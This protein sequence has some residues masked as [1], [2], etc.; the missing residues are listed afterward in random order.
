MVG[1]DGR[2]AGWGGRRCRRLR[3]RRRRV[4]RRER[5]QI[6]QWHVWRSRRWRERRCGRRLSGHERREQR[7]KRQGRWRRGWDTWRWKRGWCNRRCVRG[8]RRQRRAWRRERRQIGWRY[9]RR[10]RRWRARRCGRR[11]SGHERREQRWK[12]RL[13]WSWRYAR[14]RHQRH[15]RK[16][17]GRGHRRC[18][19]ECLVA[20][21]VALSI[22]VARLDEYGH[23]PTTAAGWISG[24]RL[25]ADCERSGV[26][27]VGSHHNLAG[28]NS[29]AALLLTAQAHVERDAVCQPRVHKHAGL[30]RA[31]HE[32]AR[33]R[34]A[35]LIRVHRDV[36]A[37]RVH[38]SQARY[39]RR[40][41]LG[42][43]LLKD[44]PLLG[45]HLS[46]VLG[47]PDPDLRVGRLRVWI[48]RDAVAP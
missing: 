47:I 34:A 10:S 28:R 44:A 39:A 30:I 11:L 29:G 38:V 45:R 17:A 7:W 9:E 24:I 8:G 40:H 18:A 25:Q 21:H 2:V 23:L 31:R 32:G 41:A 33:R 6:G 19:V 13:R 20:T 48:L 4:R 26:G 27:V 36:Q 43:W 14:V 42:R 15:E 46:E 16:R 3:Q 35:I 5:R 22:D 1:R 37:Q 12:G